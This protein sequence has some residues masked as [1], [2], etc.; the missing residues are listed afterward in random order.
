MQ[1][2]DIEKI[3]GVIAAA[4]AAGAGEHATVVEL[5]EMLKRKEKSIE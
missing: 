5:R 4:E 1:K 3:K 2:D